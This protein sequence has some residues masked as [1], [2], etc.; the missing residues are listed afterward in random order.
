MEKLQPTAAGLDVWSPNDIQHH[1][2]EHAF[3][4]L[5]EF[6]NTIE[7]NADWP[8]RFCHALGLNVIWTVGWDF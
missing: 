6:L 3:H 5:A 2:S 8:I 7:A 1:L 4:W